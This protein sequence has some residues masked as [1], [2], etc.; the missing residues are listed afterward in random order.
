MNQ[1]KE[2]KV[3]KVFLKF[4]TPVKLKFNVKDDY[5]VSHECQAFNVLESGG[6]NVYMMSLKETDQKGLYSNYKRITKRMSFEKL[7]ENEGKVYVKFNGKRVDIGVYK[8]R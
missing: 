8:D 6:T 1:V 4:G 2:K 5:G 3:R 7:S